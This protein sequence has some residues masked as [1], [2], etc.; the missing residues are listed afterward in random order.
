MSTKKAY[1]YDPSDLYEVR[2]HDQEYLNVGGVTRQ[3]RIYQPEGP[4]PFPML[5]SIH[6]G[7]WTDKD[8]TDYESTSKPLAATGLVVAAIG[9][10]VGEGF[11]Y[12]LQI[13]DIH[14]GVRWLKAHAVEFNGDPDALGGIGYSSGGHTLPLAAMRIDDS[15]Y[16]ALHLEGS[17]P[18]DARL[19]WIISCWP[20]IE[21]YFRYQIAKG[22]GNIELMEKHHMFF[23][24]DEAMH[25]STPLNVI[26]RGEELTL[27]P[28]LVLH[29]TADDV[30]PIEASERFV[31]AY[32]E[33]GGKAELVPF[34]GMGHGW[35]REAGLEV[36]EFVEIVTEFITKQLD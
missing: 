30:M 12:P 22:K 19:A 14:Y 21:P 2:V 26:Q 31:S 11:P 9:Q 1:R 33:A 34:Q 28:A 17:S 5:L 36:D 13:Q 35:A 7:A 23:Q 6:G 15:R 20:V 27:S 4:G 32:N 8:H 18:A 25:E 29:G 3:V 10:R 24:G 16:S